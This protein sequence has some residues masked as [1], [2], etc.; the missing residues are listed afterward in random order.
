MGLLDASANPGRKLL[1]AY[2]G[3]VLLPLG[4]VT[5][6]SLRLQ[7]AEA[8]RAHTR[9]V[10]L[11]QEGLR[12]IG[13]Q[14]HESL[15][16][17]RLSVMAEVARVGADPASLRA[18]PRRLVF[19]RQA[20][21][22]DRARRLVHPSLL[23]DL[24]REEEAF[25]RRTTSLWA[26]SGGLLASEGAG[27]ASAERGTTAAGVARGWHRWHV[28]DGWH[29][30]CWWREA[31]GSIVGAELDRMWILGDIVAGLPDTAPSARYRLLDAEGELLHQWG[32]Y[33]PAVD[34]RPLARESLPTPLFGWTLEHF[35][36]GGPRHATFAAAAAGVLPWLSTLGVLVLGLAFHVYRESSRGLREAAQRVGFV[37]QVS[38]EL[39]TPLT[40]IRMYAELLQEEVDEQPAARRYADV[41]VAESQR[42]SRLILNVLSF[43]RRQ[44][45]ELV[46]H[47]RPG[48]VDEV[49]ARV[50]EHF[51]PALAARGIEI[52]AVLA[53]PHRCAIDPD[54]LEQMLG[55][56][57]SNVEKY[58]PA[59]PARLTTSQQ[60]ARVTLRVAD[61]GP[62]I[63]AAE[64]ARVF[65]PF[66]RL[67][68]AL[69]E[70][71]AGTGIGL[72]I[73]RDLARLHGGDL[74]L[75]ASQ[76]P[77]ADFELTLEAP[78]SET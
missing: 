63:P 11:A 37:N 33:A 55:N 27:S 72:T 19:V 73:A 62:G 14:V 76:Q 32:A 49:V 48:V 61:R 5:W 28:D 9:L 67:S 70:G 74:R 44:K 78:E 58:A 10:E 53:A 24:D 69:T 65:E 50:L 8:E 45:H 59:A 7:G 35:G 47:R 4:A 26:G 66:R 6:L 51:R 41:I 77:G 42:L 13:G 30:L 20:F 29:L 2:L 54:A 46:V 36:P 68:H 43:A 52:E 31:D 40:N 39:K 18:L 21:H 56:L 71:V 15:E 38:H 22:L 23:D 34:E 3:V 64:S 12:G 57:L 17:R 75:V 60:G 1:A 25:V 16:A